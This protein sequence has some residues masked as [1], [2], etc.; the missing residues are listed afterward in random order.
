MVHMLQAATHLGI[1]QQKSQL[2]F[3]LKHLYDLF[4]ERDLAIAE[5]N[6]LVLTTD[7]DLCV[8]TAQM[9]ID[10]NSVYRQQEMALN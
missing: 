1:E 3:I 6:P 9:K 10:P 5:I 2:T 8:A 7:H 4:I